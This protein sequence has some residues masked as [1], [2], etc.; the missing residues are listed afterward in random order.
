VR[1]SWSPAWG[2]KGYIRLLRAD[3]QKEEVCGSD[4]TPQVITLLLL[5]LHVR[6]R[7]AL[8]SDSRFSHSCVCG[9]QYVL[10]CDAA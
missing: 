1:N 4:V 8:P 2:E 5:Y 10:M 9:A 3:S 7:N 6:I